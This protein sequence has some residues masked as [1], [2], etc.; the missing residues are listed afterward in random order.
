M[1]LKTEIIKGKR[2]VIITRKAAG[3]ENNDAIKKAIL[4]VMG[5]GYRFN[6]EKVKELE[7]R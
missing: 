6:E 4:V 3:T 5:P 2:R 1:Q 7:R